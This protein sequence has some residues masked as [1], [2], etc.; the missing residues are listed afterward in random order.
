[1]RPALS[2][3]A[4]VPGTAAQAGRRPAGSRPF[5]RRLSQ[6]GWTPALVCI[7]VYLFVVHSYRLPLG[8]TAI[9]V[10]LVALALEARPPRI[11]SFLLWW[12]AF[13][14]WALLT[15]SAGISPAASWERWLDFGKLW[16]IAFLV[17]NA[18]R[19]EKQWRI[20]IVGWLA[21]F[22]L[23][24]FRGTTVNYLSGISHMGRYAWNFAFAN[25]NDL[26]S[27]ALLMLALCVAFVKTPNPTWVRWSAR[28]GAASLPLLIVVTGSRGGLLAMAVFFAVLLAFSKRKLGTVTLG[29]IAFVI[30]FPLMPANIKQRFLNM[31]FLQDTETIGL[32]DSSAEQ[33]Y[34]ILQ[35]A[36][37]VAGDHPMFGVGLGNYPMANELYAAGR[38]EWAIAQGR[39]DSHNTY[40]TIASETGIS[41]LLFMAAAAAS[42]L[43]SLVSAQRRGRKLSAFVADRELEDALVNRPPAFIAGTISFLVAC[44][45]G[46]Y[47]YLIFPFLFAVTVQGVMH[48]SILRAE[49]ALAIR[50]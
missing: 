22:A 39:R 2:P 31:R 32:A 12:G 43:I 49:N 35:V 30:A 47:F 28:L 48:T 37:E 8:S 25:P 24:P 4:R 16:L 44:I 42:L 26:A 50:R 20:V 14:L 27:I 11:P 36:K 34:R 15:M 21:M 1:M 10:G 38:P 19:S 23:F 6:P 40:L 46:S 18:A 9:G 17:A 41:G 29:L 33:R 45:F 3:A 13:L 5:V 7:L